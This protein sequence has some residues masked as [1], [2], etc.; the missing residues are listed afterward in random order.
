MELVLLSHAV[1]L[2]LPLDV[3]KICETG[4]IN[5]DWQERAPN[6][7]VVCE[8]H[9]AIVSRKGNPKN[10]KS[11]SDLTRYAQQASC[12]CTILRTCL[13]QLCLVADKPGNVCLLA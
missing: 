7:S 2:A 4:L 11:W 12:L 8:S 10:V 3:H 5:K 6:K 13:C 1:A 9:V